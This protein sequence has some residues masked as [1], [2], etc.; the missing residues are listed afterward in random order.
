MSR[1]ILAERPAGRRRRNRMKFSKYPS[2]GSRKMIAERP[3]GRRRRNR[4]KFSKY[5]SNGSRKMIAE[6]PAGRRRRNRMKFSKYPS[7]IRPPDSPNDNF[8]LFGR[9][10]RKRLLDGKWNFIYIFRQCLHSKRKRTTTQTAAALPWP[11]GS[12]GSSKNSYWGEN[13]HFPNL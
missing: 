7:N 8:F 5:P 2:N 13:L 1:K 3:A 6:R 4:M 9:R 12:T 11:N 10:P